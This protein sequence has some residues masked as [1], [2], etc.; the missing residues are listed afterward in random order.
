M[1]G[2]GKKYASSFLFLA[3]LRL[4]HPFYLPLSP[5]LPFM[6]CQ[7]SVSQFFVCLQL[8]VNHK[9]CSDKH[10]LF[11]QPFFV[12]SNFAPWRKIV[13]ACFHVSLHFL[14]FDS[15]RRL[16]LHLSFWSF[17]HD[18]KPFGTTQRNQM[19][20]W[21]KDG[22]LV[23]SGRNRQRKP[24]H[25]KVVLGQVYT[26]KANTTSKRERITG[27]GPEIAPGVCCCPKTGALVQSKQTKQPGPPVGGGRASGGGEKNAGLG[28]GTDGTP[29]PAMWIPGQIPLT[30]RSRWGAGPFLM[31]PLGGRGSTLGRPKRL[32]A[33]CPPL[34]IDH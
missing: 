2:R 26:N 33:G 17:C 9:G 30:H 15:F 3:F 23:F 7:L 19:T 29:S 4:L 5:F 6:F 13:F 31:N 24:F 32:L 11:G 10:S 1:R 25:K 27:P 8:H 34:P 22:K 16:C 28:G 12:L 21:L 20:A 14:L 18:R